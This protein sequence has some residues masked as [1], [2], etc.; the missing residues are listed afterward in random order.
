MDGVWNVLVAWYMAAGV[1]F[2]S[3]PQEAVRNIGLEGRVQGHL[4]WL[5]RV[6][7]AEAVG[8]QN[9]QECSWNSEELLD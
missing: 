6:L 4:R 7:R 9:P 5:F 2:L 1:H 8:G 3:Q